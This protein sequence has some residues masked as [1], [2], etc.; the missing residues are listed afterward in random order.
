MAK[1]MIGT[2]VSDIQDKTIV[3][4]TERRVTHPIYR[5]QYTVSKKYQAHDDKN[6]AKVGDK[7]SISEIK[8][9]SKTKTWKLDEI[10]ERKE[11]AAEEVVA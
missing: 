6:E 8:P 5:K 4:K 7:V 3:V 2:V 9:V 11:G 1:R 10:I